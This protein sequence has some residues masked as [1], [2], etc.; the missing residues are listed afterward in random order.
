VIL[1]E[2]VSKVQRRGRRPETEVELFGESISQDPRGL[3]SHEVGEEVINPKRE[4]GLLGEASAFTHL[5]A[6]K[7]RDRGLVQGLKATREGDAT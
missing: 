6:L 7:V 3:Q 4:G 5:E 2:E 1:R